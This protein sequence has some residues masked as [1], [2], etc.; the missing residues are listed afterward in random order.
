MSQINVCYFSVIWFV[1]GTV[2]NKTNFS[3]PAAQKALGG[4]FAS[5]F[6]A[7]NSLECP[8]LASLW[9]RAHSAL[10]SLG[11]R[12]HLWVQKWSKMIFSKVVP[13][14]PAVLK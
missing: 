4:S 1:S 5:R 11:L 14:P 2:C 8:I 6:L 9:W 12:G 7:V 3:N 13:R 10:A